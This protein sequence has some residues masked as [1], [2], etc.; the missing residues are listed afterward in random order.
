M[1]DLDY[2]AVNVSLEYKGDKAEYNYKFNTFTGIFLYATDFRN[3]IFFNKL[4]KNDE[5]KELFATSFLD[6]ANHNLSS[7]NVN[8][9]A[10]EEY[11]YTHG[12]M[13]TFF[14]NRMGYVKGYL[15]DYLGVSADYATLQ[16]NTT[17]NI[18]FNTLNL[19]ENFTGEYLKC[20]PLVLKNVNIDNLLLKDL[21][22]ISNQNGKITL[23]ITG[24][25]PTITYN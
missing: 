13:K 22:I 23:M 9:K 20:Y 16:I 4:M 5:F 8:K 19:N 1:Y 11:N 10:K 25:N 15:A 6:I 21:S 12:T 2:V 7:E 14:T 17:K 3:D 24:N 18:E